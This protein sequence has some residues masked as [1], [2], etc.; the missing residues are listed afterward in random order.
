MFG[1]KKSTRER[2]QAGAPV[3]DE[4]HPLE[5]SERTKKE[6]KKRKGFNI[7]KSRTFYGVLCIL[8]GVGLVAVGIPILKQQT[9]DIV[10]VMTFSASAEQGEQITASMLEEIS[11]AS[12]NLPQGYLADADDAVGLYLVADVIEGDIVTSTRLSATPPG[13]SPELSGIPAGKM[14]LSITLSS[15]NE[16]VSSKLR[17]GDVIRIFAY[18]DND[19]FDIATTTVYMELQYVEVLSVSD[20]DGQA[21]V[22]GALDDGLIDTITV[23]VTEAQ[24]QL[25]VTLENSATVQAALVIRG[26]AETKTAALEAQDALLLQLSQVPESASVTA[27]AVV[28]EIEVEVVETEEVE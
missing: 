6:R 25:L 28:D 2:V 9:T 20:S 15:L 4:G 16:S 23:L 10:T 1:K 18:E 3:V 13:D 22:D 27:D 26:D 14:A 17:S 8:F 7:F 11:M 12:Y 5:S 19:N 21:V 24:A